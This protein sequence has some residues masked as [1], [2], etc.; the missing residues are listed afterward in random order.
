MFVCVMTK[1][2]RRDIRS[3]RTKVTRL[4]SKTRRLQATKWMLAME[5]RPFGRAARAL[6]H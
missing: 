5:S 6:N 4:S 1:K 2:A 3:F